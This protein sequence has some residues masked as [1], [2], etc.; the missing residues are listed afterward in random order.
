MHV[1][2]LGRL[3]DIGLGVV[4]KSD[5]IKDKSKADAFTKTFAI[6]QCGWLVIQSIARVAAGL[7]ITQLELA[8]M[9]FVFCAVVTYALWW[10]KPFDADRPTVFALPAS[11]EMHQAAE[12]MFKMARHSDQTRTIPSFQTGR[13]RDLTGYELGYISIPKAF[14]ESEMEI[15]LD[16]HLPSLTFYGTGTAF[17]AIHLAAWNWSFPSPLIQTLWRAL[18]VS[19]IGA[20]LFPFLIAVLVR[21]LDYFP[22]LGSAKIV[23]VT[24]GVLPVVYVIARLGLWA[25]TF[26]CFSSMPATVYDTVDWTGYLLHFS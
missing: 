23:Y 6:F 5:D 3:E 25:L 22:I 8:T 16:T 9:A 15:D 18:G 17:S 21:T 24:I 2:C 11:A 7:S 1:H 14:I 13:T 19:A 4:I 20:S 10:D 26:Y 12:E